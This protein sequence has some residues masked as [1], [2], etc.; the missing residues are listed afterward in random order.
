V[1][2]ALLAGVPVIAAVSAPTSLAVTLAE[3][4]GLTLIGFVREQSMNVYAG[5]HRVL[6]A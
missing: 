3:E 5:A 2:K 1:Q 4:S 6:G